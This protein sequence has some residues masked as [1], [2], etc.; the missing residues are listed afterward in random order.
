MFIEI[1]LVLILIF[2]IIIATQNSARG[3]MH[4]ENLSSIIYFLN[5]VSEAVGYLAAE[6]KILNRD[7]PFLNKDSPILKNN[8]PLNRNNNLDDSYGTKEKL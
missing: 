6:R 5:S 4:A 2:L 8:V 3:G 1:I 7:N